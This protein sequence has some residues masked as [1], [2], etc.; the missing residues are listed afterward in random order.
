MNTKTIG[1]T[2]SSLRKQN[3]MTQSDLAKKM[4]VTDK[5]VSKWE[6]NLSYPDITSISKLAK[7]L[8]VDSSYLIDLCGEKNVMKDKVRNN[9]L[10]NNACIAVSLAM[11]IAVIVLNIFNQVEIKNAITLLSIGLVS[12]SFYMLN[13]R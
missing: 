5:A 8:G 2:I 3:N 13:N 9:D 4:N 6:R 12:I 1:E 7:I 11:G 10:I